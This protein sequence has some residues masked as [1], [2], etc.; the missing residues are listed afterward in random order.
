MRIPISTYRLQFNRD[1]RFT[2]AL[3]LVDYL[4]E[5]GITDLY[6]SPILKARPGS[7]HGYDVT[8]PTQLN[9]E[10]G[11]PEEFDELCRALQ[12]RGI[13]LILDIV[14]NHMAASLDNPWW[15]DVL[16]KGEGSAYAQFFDVNW[17]SKKVLLPILGRPYGEALENQELRLTIENGRPILTYFEQKL[18]IAAGAENL[19][20]E[21]I[22]GI[23]SRQHYRLAY[24][25]KAADS[26]NYRRFFD[27]SDLV[28][29]RVERE[30]VY[31]AVH[32]YVL[33]LVAEGKITGLRI[34]H[35]DG[36]LDP[37]GYLDHLP[38]AYVITEKILAGTEQLPCDWRTHGTTGYDFL[39]FLN[40]A[41]IDQE[42]FHK[43]EKI[44]ADFTGSPKTFTDAFREYKQ[45]V[46]K[47]LFVG[48]LNALVDRLSE[49]AEDDRHARD[50]RTEELRDAFVSVTACMPVYRTYI[51]DDRIS[52]A[53]RAYIENA[54]TAAGKGGAFDFLRR[55]LL[56]EPSW[57]I[58][59]RKPDCLDFVMRWQQFTGPV[60]AKG[61]EDTA[62]YVHTP[63]LSVNEVGGDSNGPEIYFGVEEFHR[64]NLA[65]HARWPHTLNATS[66]HDTKRS[67]DVRARINVLSELPQD[68]ARCLR[69]WQRMN[70]SEAAPDRNEQILIYQSMLGAW[71]IEPNRLKQ[72][73]TKALREAKT[74]TSWIDINEEYEEQVLS[75]VDSLYS[76]E[77]FLEDFGR[78]QKKIAY[79]GAFSSL[80]Q[81]ILK[82]TS[83]G[84]P[85][86]YRGAELWDLSLADPDNRRPVDFAT[87]QKIFDEVKNETKLPNLL[88]RYSD[89][90]LKMF[91]T[92]KALQFRRT[93]SD[94]F[95]EGEYIPLRVTGAQ[96]NHVIAF[97]R[98]LHKRWLIVAVP[99]LF[100][101]L[102]RAGSA[103][104]GEK[105][106]RD[107]QIGLPSGIPARGTNVFT[108][109]E[110]STGMASDLF[111]TL[112]FAVV[113]CQSNVPRRTILA[114]LK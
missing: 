6:A 28:G 91:V 99:R 109:E 68:W 112:P 17:E 76:N 102:T 45:Q 95:T 23:L 103:P 16:E 40:C 83:P 82:I 89:G 64:R 77:T 31:H 86:L 11:T 100:A 35:I 9:P 60:M 114:T 43:L 113:D 93:Q 75:F 65:R 36:L 1:F 12:S 59:H 62:F 108:N 111:T 87:R 8:D 38:E 3:R 13:G 5:L 26:I 88:K 90:R 20:V 67:E 63:L 106:W 32:A 2:D 21:T 46:M 55:V 29:L 58:Q 51:R 79:F 57:Y 4:H 80:S 101:S 56:L 105:I 96:S 39:N 19:S 44:Y 70:P 49:L 18:P 25:R 24:W 52:D 85:D 84:V 41:F 61:L 37:K 78:L 66:T 53:D 50:L 30:D 92:W 97:A 33:K 81:L 110:V 98:Y 34:D 10:I 22:D 69:R 94:L 104:I 54:I 27:I 72:Y 14:P 48:E 47:E 74:H 71:P 42:G 107:T 15:F 73:V 7:T